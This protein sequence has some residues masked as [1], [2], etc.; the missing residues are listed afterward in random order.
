M[1]PEIFLSREIHYAL[2]PTNKSNCVIMFTLV[3][4]VEVRMTS[5]FI[6]EPIHS[7]FNKTA[8]KCVGLEVLDVVLVRKH[9]VPRRHI[10]SSHLRR[11]LGYH[12]S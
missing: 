8:L 9:A 4:V 2:M 10:Q 12:G 1:L 6:N 7:A 5:T 11:T 3:K